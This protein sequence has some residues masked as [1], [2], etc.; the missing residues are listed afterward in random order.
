MQ[1]I[2]NDRFTSYINEN[3]FKKD[4]DGIYTK[5]TNNGDEKTTYQAL[6]DQYLL[7]KAVINT[8][9]TQVLNIEAGYKQDCTIETIHPLQAG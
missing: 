9:N 5:T 7:S 3:K 8:S 4:S 2:N 1:N 6:I